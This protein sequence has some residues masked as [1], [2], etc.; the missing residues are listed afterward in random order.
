M[1]ATTTTARRA[2]YVAD[3]AETVRTVVNSPEAREARRRQLAALKRSVERDLQRVDKLPIA[4]HR[5]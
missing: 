5:A 2:A 3:A 4:I 1:T